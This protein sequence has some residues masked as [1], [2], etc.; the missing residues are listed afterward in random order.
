MIM[1]H[2]I[3]HPPKMQ[4]LNNFLERYFIITVIVTICLSLYCHEYIKK[5]TSCSVLIIVLMMF[6]SALNTGKV[7]IQ[8]IKINVVFLAIFFAFILMPIFSY[9]IGKYVYNNQLDLITG[10]VLTSL[11]PIG[12]SSLFWVS[13]AGGNIEIPLVI[14]FLT[15]FLN[16]IFM[17]TFIKLLLQTN[18]NVNMKDMIIQLVIMLIVPFSVGLLAGKKLVKQVESFK[19]HINFFMRILLLCMILISIS[20]IVDEINN[21]GILLIKVLM[22]DLVQIVL[23]YIVGFLISKLILKMDYSDVVGFMYSIS[24]RNYAVGLVL[25]LN[26]FGSLVVIPI[27]GCIMLQQSIAGV[28]CNIMEKS[29]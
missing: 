16:P 6:L 12:L 24:M 18:I 20:S 13:L 23:A 2:V 28:V 9:M 1:K 19:I 29:E 26:Y 4:K 11:I 14:V 3:K 5:F 10:Q 8:K 25:S 15:T 21:L 7:Y 27:I 22:V 17:S